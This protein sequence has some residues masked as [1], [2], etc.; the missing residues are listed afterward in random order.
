[1]STPMEGRSCFRKCGRRRKRL[2]LL[3]E[4][5]CRE[6][7]S[8]PSTPQYLK[9]SEAWRAIDVEEAARYQWDESSTY[10]QNP[11]F[12]ADLDDDVSERS[13]IEGGSSPGQA[14]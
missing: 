4:H 13:D 10:I 14:L 11:P 3:Y 7:S 6:I 2:T 5:T 1:M 9:S 12:F 8:K